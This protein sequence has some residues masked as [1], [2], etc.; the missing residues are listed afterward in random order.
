MHGAPPLDFPKD[1]MAEVMGSHH[2]DGHA[3]HDHSDKGHSSADS[4]HSDTAHARQLHRQRRARLA[5]KMRAWP[6]TPHNDPF[7]AGSQELAEH[8]A[9]ASGCEVV[10]GFNEFCDPTVPAALDQAIAGGAEKVVVITPMM[11]KG[12]EHSELD[13]SSA[14]HSA[15]KRHP[16]VQVVYAWPFEVAVVAQFLA[17]QVKRF[18]E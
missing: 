5:A 16:N 7:Y 10:V 3:D 1:E 8:L 11:T 18:S 2:Y 13:I 14:V 15:Q 4:E 9:A 12:G 6:R 17:S